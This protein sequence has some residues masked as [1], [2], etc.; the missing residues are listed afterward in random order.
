[1]K[2]TVLIL[3]LFLLPFLSVYVNNKMN[4]Y[5]IVVSGVKSSVL[6]QEDFNGKKQFTDISDK[7]LYNNLK[8]DNDNTIVIATF[9]Q[10][11]SAN[12][13]EGTYIPKKRV[14]QYFDGKIY[15]GSSPSLG[16]TGGEFC[17]ALPWRK[18]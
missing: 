7:Q 8:L 18:S 17:V 15:N 2:K 4:F 3:F 1:M 10:S 14:Y 11:N 5:S 6:H 16:A 13:G 12:Y 9:G